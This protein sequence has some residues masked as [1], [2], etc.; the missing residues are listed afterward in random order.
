MSFRL[1]Y[2]EVHYDTAQQEQQ[3]DA[4]AAAGWHLS[5]R[6]INVKA[7]KIRLKSVLRALHVPFN[8][9]SERQSGLYITKARSAAQANLLCEKVVLPTAAMQH[10]LCC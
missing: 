9:A 6:C 4:N 2:S 3:S 10:G 8:V 7:N 5:L 1:W